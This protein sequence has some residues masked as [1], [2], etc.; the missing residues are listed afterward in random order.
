MKVELNILR[1]VTDSPGRLLHVA[2]NQN[3]IYKNDLI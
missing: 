1:E 2:T 3:I